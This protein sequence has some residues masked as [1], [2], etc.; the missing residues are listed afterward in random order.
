LLVPEE[1]GAVDTLELLNRAR[2]A[3]NMVEQRLGARLSRLQTPC[4]LHR[5]DVVSE[6]DA[7]DQACL[8]ARA[9]DAFVAL[10]PNG[11]PQE[12]ARFAETVIFGAGRHV[13]LVPEDTE[14]GLDLKRV[15]VG[16]NGSRE[17]A[18]AL[19][20][21]LPYLKRA[22]G[23]VILAVVEDEEVESQAGF[24]S[25]AVRHLARHGVEAKLYP[26]KNHMNDAGETLLVEALGLRAGLIVMGGYG[27]SRL[28]EWLL[29]GVTY[30][31]LHESSIPLLIAH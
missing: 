17:A 26:V 4:E 2:E 12:P 20:E 23:V 27:H 1:G 14:R 8:E 25:E 6:A 3:G 28:R 30:K 18:R 24:G 19:A 10:R 13:I 31:L 21:G 9:A 29:G 5:H 7:A 11:V 16:W 22:E 15:V